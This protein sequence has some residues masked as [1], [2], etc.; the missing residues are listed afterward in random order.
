MPTIPLFAVQG[1]LPW[2]Q[3]GPLQQQQHGDN[4]MLQLQTLLQAR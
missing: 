2:L 3:V 4:P 1:R